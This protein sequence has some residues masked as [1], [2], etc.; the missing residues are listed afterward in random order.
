M[1]EKERLGRS[2]ATR[3]LGLFED[4]LVGKVTYIVRS[5]TNTSLERTVQLVYRPHLNARRFQVIL[6]TFLGNTSLDTGEPISLGG[7]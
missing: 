5:V 4:G 3:Q 2:S 6:A 7:G 1:A